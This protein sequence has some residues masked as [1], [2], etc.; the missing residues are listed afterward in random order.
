MEEKCCHCGKLHNQEELFAMKIE[1]K[2]SVCSLACG[3]DFQCGE[4]DIIRHKKMVKLKTYLEGQKMRLDHP[5][6]RI[7]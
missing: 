6:F 7:D 4:L 3:M 2:W 5:K 1:D